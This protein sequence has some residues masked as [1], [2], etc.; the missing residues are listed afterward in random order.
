MLGRTTRSKYL[1][2]GLLLT[3]FKFQLDRW[4]SRAGFDREWHWYSYLVPGLGDSLLALGN[5]DQMPAL[6][7]FATALPFVAAGIVL[8][9]RRLRD[10]GLTPSLAL[11]FF[12]PVVNIFLFT[13]LCFLPSR[14]PTDSAPKVSRYAALLP[15][16]D[17][18]TALAAVVGSALICAVCAGLATEYLRN[19]GWGL[20]VGIPFLSG[21][22]AAVA[23]SVYDRRPLRVCIGLASL[24]VAIQG[25][26]LIAF[27]LEGF[28]CVLMAVPLALPLA[29]LGAW[30]GWTVSIIPS[31]RNDLGCTAMAVLAPIILYADSK[32]GMDAAVLP[33]TTSQIIYAP[34]K[35]VWRNVV[36]FSSL[37][38]ATE[39]IFKV[40]IAY[41][42]HATIEGRGVGAVRRCQFS[43]GPF[44]EPITV[45]DEP[46]LL[47][48][49]VT[50]QPRPMDEL[51]IWKDI[52]PPHLD[53]L[54]ESKGGEFRLTEVQPGITLL[55]GTT[56]YSNQMWPERYWRLWS[57]WLIHKIH[58]RVLLHIKTISEK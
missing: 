19:Y 12:V 47:A 28:I 49:S 9:T 24:A 45:W 10:A 52:S 48:F 39:W 16:S 23:S 6:T 38:P 2:T 35:T 34:R 5:T 36:E 56:W 13:L 42:T 15:K 26:L 57:D 20:F 40:G 22:L 55:Q 25:M 30:L 33:V 8:T 44:V 7:L 14:L 53:G 46:N 21:F 11:L 32:I 43:T 4:L 17:F 41:P 27:A 51:S 54:L 29:W 31:S 3:V 37:P 1:G 50:Q 58:R 18:G